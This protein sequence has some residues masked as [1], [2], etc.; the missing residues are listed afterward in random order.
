VKSA[1]E[2]AMTREFVVMV[3]A[4]VDDAMELERGILG[5]AGFEL[6]A[7]QCR[8]VPALL[9]AARG[10]AGIMMWPQIWL[11]R[12][13]E[14]VIGALNGCRAIVTYSVGFDHIDLGAAKERG[15]GVSNTPDWCVDEVANHVMTLLL[16]ANK[17]LALND[18][19]LRAGRWDHRAL[20]PL[21]RITGQT[22]GLVGVGRIGA[23]V[24]ARARPFGLRTVAYDPFVSA[25]RVASLGAE[26]LDSLDALLEASDYVSLHVPLTPATRHLIGA[27]QLARMR[28]GAYIINAARGP[29]VDE[30]A[31]VEALRAGWIAGAALD[32]YEHE[33]LASDSPLLALD[34]VT[35]TPH[36]ASYSEEG[37]V[38]RRQKAAE[39]IVRYL[40]G[41]P[42]RTPLI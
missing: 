22:L 36:C 6:R 12:I 5:A 26:P 31:L 28:P 40:S 11:P 33:P 17:K 13:S 42:P 35:L 20:R 4:G 41:R 38:E 19:T 32:V 34:N 15:I 24:A 16:A 39:E 7:A 10:A 2:A 37:Y 27:E 21:H 1:K 18:R 3:D 23:A 30:R 25:E 29:V 9:E 8:D 14:G